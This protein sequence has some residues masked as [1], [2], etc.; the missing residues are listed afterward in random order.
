MTVAKDGREAGGEEF[1]SV[2]CCGTLGSLH[3]RGGYRLACPRPI[4]L[5]FLPIMAESH[6]TFLQ[7]CNFYVPESTIMVLS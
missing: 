4:N 1:I 7:Y 6:T 2:V 3:D 5:L